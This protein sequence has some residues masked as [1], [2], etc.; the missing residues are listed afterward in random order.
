MSIFFSLWPAQKEAK[1]AIIWSQHSL[2]WFSSRTLKWQQIAF[3]SPP[4][5]IFGA[6]FESDQFHCWSIDEPSLAFANVRRQPL[7]RDWPQIHRRC[8]TAAHSESS[9]SWAIAFI[10]WTSSISSAHLQL[11]WLLCVRRNHVRYSTIDDSLIAK[12]VW[13]Y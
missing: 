6:K 2:S 1:P 10:W 4:A 8:S 3:L 7:N 5:F 12:C 13:R 11:S 9:P